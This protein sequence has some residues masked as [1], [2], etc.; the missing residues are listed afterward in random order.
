[1]LRTTLIACLFALQGSTQVAPA[2]LATIDGNTSSIW[3]FDMGVGRYQQIHRHVPGPVWITSIAFRRNQGSPP[4]PVPRWWTDMVIRMGD[5]E[6][7]RA[8]PSFAQNQR[9][10][11]TVV[12]TP[13]RIVLPDWSV[14]TTATPPPFDFVIPFDV[15]YLH[16]G[17]HPLLWEIDLLDH[18]NVGALGAV[19]AFTDSV[20]T[21][22]NAVPVGISCQVQLTGSVSAT[23]ENQFYVWFGEMP[24][25]YLTPRLF[26]FGFDDPN[27]ALPELCAPLRVDPVAIFDPGTSGIGFYMPYDPGLT[28]MVFRAQTIRL[29]TL[30]MPTSNAVVMTMPAMPTFG[31]RDVVQV[32]QP[33]WGPPTVARGRGV[34]VK[35]Q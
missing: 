4:T 32:Y 9:T 12:V 19:D 3:P 11:A 28:G 18:A 33:S 22:L 16:T 24:Y 29:T 34:V 10:P 17:Q 20:F 8:G 26:G 6:F 21:T 5:G 14:P 2:G 35:L 1:M 31:D 13:K 23:T 15:P 27:L 7:E 30:P 25:P